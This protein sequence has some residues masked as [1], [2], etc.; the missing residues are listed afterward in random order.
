MVGPRPHD[1]ARSPELDDTNQLPI[2]A[3][4]SDSESEPNNAARMGGKPHVAGHHISDTDPATATTPESSSNPSPATTGSMLPNNLDSDFLGQLVNLDSIPS[5]HACGN[6]L[7]PSSPTGSFRPG[8]DT[9]R[10]ESPDSEYR[11]DTARRLSSCATCRSLPGSH[12]YYEGCIRYVYTT[13]KPAGNDMV[14][15]T[16]DD[17]KGPVITLTK[18]PHVKMAGRTVSDGN[19]S[20]VSV[21]TTNHVTLKL[22]GV[23]PARP[24]SG[25][26]PWKLRYVGGT[27]LLKAVMPLDAVPT[28][29]SMEV[30]HRFEAAKTLRLVTDEEFFLD[31]LTRGDV[32]KR[33]TA[34]ATEATEAVNETPWKLLLGEVQEA[35]S[36]L[37]LGPGGP[38]MEIY[39]SPLGEN[40]SLSDHG[41]GCEVMG[42]GILRETRLVYMEFI[43]EFLCMFWNQFERRVNFDKCADAE[44]EEQYEPAPMVSRITLMGVFPPDWTLVLR[45]NMP[46]CIVEKD[47]GCLLEEAAKYECKAEGL[48][49]RSWDEEDEVDLVSDAVEVMRARLQRKI[50]VSDDVGPTRVR[51]RP[52]ALVAP[53][54]D[55]AFLD[56]VEDSARLKLS[57]GMERMRLGMD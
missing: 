9:P 1:E 48:S 57:A 21:P 22:G 18:C 30:R 20:S 42:A 7:N 26:P 45:E 5:H 23:A 33:A 38:A 3:S 32:K 34:E 8:W 10:A 51:T 16:C 29:A 4:E 39:V 19:R 31:T 44:D 15:E 55:K 17:C 56:E 14:I 11:E 36:R 47:L 54:H 12:W 41:L 13:Y 46:W 37:H 2:S 40:S 53:H 28:V 43:K 25:H 27:S 49:L 35:I 6:N 52:D 24:G 50:T